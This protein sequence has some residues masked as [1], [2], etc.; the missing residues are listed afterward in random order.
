MN[1]VHC[2]K[3]LILIASIFLSLKA[4]ETVIPTTWSKKPATPQKLVQRI[5]SA[6]VRAAVN[7]PVS[8]SVLY[9]IGYPEDLADY[10]ALDGNA[11][12]LLTAM[13]HHRDELPLKSVYV[14]SNGKRVELRLIRVVLSDQSEADSPS[15]KVFGP[16][17]ADSLYLLPMELRI[18]AGVLVVDF[19][20]NHS[21]VQV[22]K[23]GSPLPPELVSL[24]SH[25]RKGLFPSKENLEAFI[26]KEFP[27]FTIR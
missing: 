13:S 17:R 10:T 11:V 27:A 5:E 18:A 14:D 22:A 9:D 19:S 20:K 4:Q 12:L 1:Y 8:H 24:A 2:I 3:S 6:A 7:G 25:P 21:G 23:F 15:I 16:Y 26:N